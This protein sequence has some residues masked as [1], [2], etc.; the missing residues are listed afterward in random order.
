MTELSLTNQSGEGIPL[1]R[2]GMAAVVTAGVL[3][4]FEL[5]KHSFELFHGKDCH[6]FIRCCS[7]AEQQLSGDPHVHCSVFT[8][9]FGRRFSDE[10]A[11]FNRVVEQKMLAVDD[12]WK[13]GLCDA[14]M[15]LDSDLLI[16]STFAQYLLKEDIE[17]A[18]T[19]H[20]WHPTRLPD[21][22]KF[23]FFNSGFIYTTNP[24]F[25]IWWR[26]AFLSQPHLYTD[27]Q[28][29]NDAPEKFRVTQ[30]GEEA[31]VSFWRC[32]SGTHALTSYRIPKDSWF[33]H[34]HFF[35]PDETSQQKISNIFSRLFAQFTT[36]KGT[37][38]EVFS[39]YQMLHKTFAFACLVYLKKSDDP[40]HQE[41]YNLILQNDKLQIYSAVFESAA[42]I[43]SR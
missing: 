19:P 17:V 4:E 36:G 21:M 6:W 1:K 38:F 2:L 5:M 7:K 31:N 40:R 41:L 27:Q 9:N 23:G 3:Q 33:V 13:S 28:C 22:Q 11:G 12:A 30:L 15:F 16:I 14:V 37:G 32:E 42:T 24:Q 34:V 20:H 39:F 25:H 18:L 26:S 43:A 35:Q 29:L 10:E 8:E